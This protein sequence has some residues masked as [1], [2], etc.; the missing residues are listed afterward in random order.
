MC[1]R[2]LYKKRCTTFEILIPF[3]LCVVFPLI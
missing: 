1:F 2:P 3:R